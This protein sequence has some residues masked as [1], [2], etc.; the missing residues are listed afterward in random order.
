MWLAETLG[1]RQAGADLIYIGDDETDED[2]FR[3]LRQRGAG[4]GI[5]VTAQPARTA[6]TYYLRDCDE[7]YR[8]LKSLAAVLPTK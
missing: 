1:L 6:A 5:L 4:I 3:D 2:A 8:F 7:V